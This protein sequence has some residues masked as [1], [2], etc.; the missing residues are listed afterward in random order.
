[1][2]LL[3]SPLPSVYYENCSAARNAGVAPLHADEPGYRTGLDGDEDGVAC[4]R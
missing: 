4:E 3:W 1:V 2:L